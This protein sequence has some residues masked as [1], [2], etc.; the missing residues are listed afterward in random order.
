M[1][2]SEVHDLDQSMAMM[3]LKSGQQK[4]ALLFSLKKKSPKSF[5]KMLAQVEKYANMEEGYDTH[6]APAKAK[7]E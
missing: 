2:T 7:A 4:N 6:P 5:A 1:A 3:I